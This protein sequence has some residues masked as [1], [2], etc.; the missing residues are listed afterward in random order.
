[1]VLAFVFALGFLLGTQYDTTWLKINQQQQ[2]T[3]S[4]QQST[5]S[6]RGTL[7]SLQ[8]STKPNIQRRQLQL[9]D[10]ADPKSV[11]Y[12]DPQFLG[13][14]TETD[15]HPSPLEVTSQSQNVNV[16]DVHV[17]SMCRC[18]SKAMPIPGRPSQIGLNTGVVQLPSKATGM[19]HSKN[20]IF[21]PSDSEGEGC[22]CLEKSD[23]A[24]A[25]KD[26]YLRVLKR[27]CPNPKYT[28]NYDWNEMPDLGVED[29]LPLFFGVL[30]YEAPLSLNGTLHNWLNHDFF[31]RTNAK[32]VF[33]QLN[34]RSEKDDEVLQEFQDTLVR[35]KQPPLTLMGSPDENLNPGDRKS[36]V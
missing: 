1:M 17:R 5:L 29:S 10:F 25:T 34:K 27:R 6:M 32:D 7:S 3:S 24:E 28:G 26:M 12:R 18:G 30:S 11:N 4:P 31:R 14:P 8:D 20:F 22:T 9:Q 2:Q 33:V 21:H 23:F 36:V 35:D 13:A 15:Q 19:H 16:R